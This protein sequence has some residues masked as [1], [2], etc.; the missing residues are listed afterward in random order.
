[1]R[2]KI[3]VFRNRKITNGALVTVNLN[4]QK[5]KMDKLLILVNVINQVLQPQ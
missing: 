2:H 4:S 5:I 1:M 3:N